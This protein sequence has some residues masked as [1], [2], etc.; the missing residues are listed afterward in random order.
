MIKRLQ[1]RLQRH[2]DP[3]RKAWWDAYLKQVITFR[4]VPMAVIRRE[5]CELSKADPDRVAAFAENHPL[6]KEA[7]KMAL[8]K[9]TGRGRR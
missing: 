3:K 2:A 8:A 4:G 5:V 9:I 1:T 6:S 7:R